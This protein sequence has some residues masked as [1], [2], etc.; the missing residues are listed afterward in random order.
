MVLAVLFCVE[1]RIRT[2]LNAARMSAAGEGSTAPNLYFLSPQA[3]E[4]ANR[5]H[6]PPPKVLNAKALR[7]F[8]F[9]LFTIHFSLNT[10]SRL[11]E[12]NK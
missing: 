5:I 1:V 2:H 9:Y 4:N 11:L 6:H 12:S 8:T 7:T 3:K 10:H